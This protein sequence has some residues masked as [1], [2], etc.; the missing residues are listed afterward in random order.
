VPV[1]LGEAP[2]LPEAAWLLP[3]RPGAW[4]E[5]A[6]VWSGTA[7]AALA[8][9]LEAIEPLAW[10]ARQLLGGQLLRAARR[11]PCF[12]SAAPAWGEG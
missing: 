5:A 7:D 2:W 4:Q 3:G 8:Q 10:Q 6:L 11:R 1:F 12:G 9:Q